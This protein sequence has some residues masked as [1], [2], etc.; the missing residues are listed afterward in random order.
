MKTIYLSPHLD[1]AVFSCGGWIWEQVQKGQEVEI[2]TIFAGAEPS[3]GLSDL[4][5]SIHRSWKLTEKVVQTR[6]EEDREACRILGVKG[7]YFPFLDCIYRFS[8]HGDP[9]YHQVEDI[10]SGL[11]PREHSLIDEVNARLEDL[12]PDEVELVVPLAI[13]NHVDHE[14]TRK[15]V[16]RLGRPLYYYADYPYAREPEGQ[17]IIRIMEK[18]R[19]WQA[20]QFPVSEE[21]LDQWWMAAQAYASQ[22]STFWVGRE[23]LRSEIRDFSGFLGGF[24]R[25]EAL[26]EDH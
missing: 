10:F 15:A 17:E 2:W 19:E 16:S 8:P 1:D 23:A 4:A 20:D 5:R 18:S 12:V 21:G 22:L 11:D 3:E 6:W 9:Y 7:R 25:W 24:K 14:V 13:G 26:E